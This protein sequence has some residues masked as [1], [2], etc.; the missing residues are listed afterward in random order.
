MGTTPHDEEETDGARG[1][2]EDKTDE[3]RTLQTFVV[4]LG[5]ALNA[6]GESVHVVQERLTR[7]AVA[8]GATTARVSAFPTYTM[9]AMGRGEPATLEN[10]FAVPTAP[11][12]DQIAALDRL[13]QQAE[14]GSVPPLHGLRCLEDI[15]RMRPRFGSVQTAIG[16]SILTVGLCLILQPAARDVAVAAV[17]GAV[18]GV[19]SSVA[20]GRR[21]LAILLPVTAAFTVSAIA[22]LAV[23]NDLAGP[24]LRATV[25]SLVVFLP[26]AALTT[27]V[28]ELTSGQMISGASRLVSGMVQLGLLTFGIAAG[29]QAVHVPSAEV[30][31]P[32]HDTFGAWLGWLG[33]MVFAIGVTIANSAPARSFPGLLVVLYVAWSGQVVGNA[34]LGGYVS[35]FV[36]ALVMTPVAVWVSRLPSAMPPMASF[37]PGFWLLVP[38]ALGLMGLTQF[39][40]EPSTLAVRDLLNTVVAILSITIG[41]LCGSLLGGAAS[42]GGRM[43]GKASALAEQRSWLHRLRGRRQAGQDD[44]ELKRGR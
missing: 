15:R 12:L 37:L 21:A 25:A 24:G 39:A 14:R 13:V 29:I 2:G 28:L 31:R 34:V 23:E 44:D 3:T 26:G 11:R 10:T 17:L 42:T 27:A 4:E 43:L 35:G 38:G 32:S 33:V 22:A 40:G 36:G 7:V 19:Q 5:A 8:Y 16:Y 1:V 20:Q 41:V 9:V 18:V 30:F 6:A